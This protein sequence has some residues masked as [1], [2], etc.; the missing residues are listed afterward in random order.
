LAK[1]IATKYG[2]LDNR[3]KAMTNLNQ[4]TIN[5]RFGNGHSANINKAKN[6]QETAA[7]FQKHRNC[8]AAQVNVA[9]AYEVHNALWDVDNICIDLNITAPLLWF[10]GKYDSALQSIQL[11]LRLR[12]SLKNGS[13]GYE[14][15]YIYAALLYKEERYKE[16][17]AQWA[18]LYKQTQKSNCESLRVKI[19]NIATSLGLAQDF[20]GW[21]SF[22]FRI[23]NN[24]TRQ[25]V[26][27]ALFLP[28]LEELLYCDCI[29]ISEDN[30]KYTAEIA[31]D[32]L[33]D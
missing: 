7:L 1:E 29:A 24:V 6:H 19:N 16:A 12:D 4:A 18:E 2:Y 20:N 15:Q 17:L 21:Q 32:Y 8:L 28:K 22:K 3:N 33:E 30:K 27:A 14:S 5:N 13:I 25:L 26:N 31:A 10:K 9:I 11:S 23:E